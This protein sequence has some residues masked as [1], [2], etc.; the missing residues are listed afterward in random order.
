MS[1]VSRIVFLGLVFGLAASPS[2]WAQAGPPAQG[3]AAQ[4]LLALLCMLFIA[5]LFVALI[6]FMLMTIWRIRKIQTRNLGQI[7][8]SLALSEENLRL[9]REQVA[10]Q[11]ETNRLL[12]ELIERFPRP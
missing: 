5:V 8:R 11:A 7:D 2:A 4:S 9:T 10:L 3:E 6:V 1:Q 12:K